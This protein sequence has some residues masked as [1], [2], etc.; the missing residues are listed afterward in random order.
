MDPQILKRAQAWL[1]DPSYDE[2]TQAEVRELLKHPD[3]LTDAFFTELSFGTGGLRGI[4]GAGSNRINIYTIRKASQGLANY[5]LK[6]GSPSSGVV[7]GFDSRHHSAEFAQEAA[8]VFTGNGIQV[9]LLKE[10]RPTPYVSFATRH[11]KAQA[12][13]MITASHNPKE[14]NGYKVFW[15]D[16]GQVVPPHDT[17]IMAEVDAVSAIKLAEMTDPSIL[18]DEAY[19][20][21]LSSLQHFPGENHSSLKIS[22]TSLHGTGITLMPEALRRWGFS[23]PH[24]VASQAVPD[25]DFPTVHFPNP[26]YPEALKAGIEDLIQTGSDILIATDPDADRL[27]VVASHQGK[28]VTLNG[29]EQAALAAY[30]ICDTL[31]KQKKMPPKGAIVTTIVTTELLKQIAKAFNIACFEVLTGFKYIGEKIHQ[32]EQKS[33]GYDFLFGAEESYG[34][35]MGTYARDKDAMI[36]G[37]LFAEISVKLKEQGKTLI[38]LLHEIYAKFG[39]FREKQMSLTFEEGKKGLDTIQRLMAG[40][41]KNSPMALGGQKVIELEDY[42]KGTSENLPRSDVLLY[43][44]ED[45]SKVIIRPSGTEPK[46]KVYLA[47]HAS[48]F[49]SISYGLDSCNRRLDVLQAALKKE[50]C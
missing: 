33:G 32:W 11:L 28:P 47:A 39:V 23:A 25:G 3:Q 26:E 5:I 49:Q 38:D 40:L 41:R 7:I 6:N 30:F 29:N 13:I 18:I 16:G 19:L 24:L 2:K 4:M 46:L 31:T 15:Q 50:L 21:A 34:Y 44:L 45:Q 9:F 1:E 22:Y 35:L 27:G 37:C 48:Q 10:L 36:A 20:E 14:Y 12:G 17:G 43:R 8:K 42:L